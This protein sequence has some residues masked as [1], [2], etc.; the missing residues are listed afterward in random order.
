MNK[1]QFEK[2]V[3]K[4]R[5]LASQSYEY[6]IELDSRYGSVSWNCW[7]ASERKQ[8]QTIL[9]RSSKAQDRLFAVLEDVGSRDWSSGV[10]VRWIVENITWEMATTNDTIPIP[11]PAYG[12][13]AKFSRRF[14]EALK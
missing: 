10:P 5:K 12:Q 2:L 7:K 14:A 6:R 8:Y 4:C 11:P 3:G 13:D 1:Q 9:E